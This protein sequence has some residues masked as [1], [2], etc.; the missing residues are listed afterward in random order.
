MAYAF[1]R[2]I[3]SSHRL[4]KEIISDKDKLFTSKFWKSL[5]DFISINYKLSTSFHPTTNGQT[6]R[7]NQTLE[8]Y[9]RHYV[10]YKQNNWVSLLPMAQLAYNSS[11]AS[12]TGISPFQANYGFQPIT[13]YEPKGLQTVA[14]K[15]VIKILSLI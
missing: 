3:I 2:N 8:Q 11:K 7:L 15:T 4:S 12:I 9:L 13:I 5:M 1:L 14:Q 10:N 6:E